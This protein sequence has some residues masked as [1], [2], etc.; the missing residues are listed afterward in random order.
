MKN[1]LKNL[2]L[3]IWMTVLTGIVY[4][5]GV[6]GIARLTM[7]KKASGS[8]LEAEGK[9]IGSRLIA[10]KFESDKYFW[11]RPSFVN[12]NPMPS[13]AS[14]LG[15]ISPALKKSVEE[16]KAAIAAAHK[17]SEGDLIP[18]EL[19]FASGSGVDP[20]ISRRAAY[21]QIDRIADARGLESQSAKIELKKLIHKKTQKRSLKFI[22]EPCVCVLE[23]NM[24]L[25][26]EVKRND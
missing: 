5:L 8:F 23:L 21:F 22:G 7:P 24:A 19:L 11:P 20:H 26:S 17:M 13:G 25:D 2:R 16:R 6:T 14:N 15:P 1:F 12:Y 3:F 4:P 10:Q 18:S 9:I